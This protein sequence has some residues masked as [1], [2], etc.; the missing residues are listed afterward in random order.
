ML[1]PRQVRRQRPAV[2]TA[3]PGPLGPLNRIGSLLAGKPRGLD[4]LGFLEPERQLI[5]R[6]A[7]PVERS[8][9]YSRS[10]QSGQAGL[11]KRIKEIAETR[12]AGA[13]E[14][15]TLLVLISGT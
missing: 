5:D 9:N 6:Q 10:R 13:R 8:T 3:L 2:G 14:R 1:D 7:L 15:R 12:S 11:I 4:L